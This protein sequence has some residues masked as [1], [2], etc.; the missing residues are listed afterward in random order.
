M[1][2]Q[3]EEVV[4]L[5]KERIA[6]CQDVINS[7]SSDEWDDIFSEVDE[8]CGIESLSAEEQRESEIEVIIHLREEREYYAALLANLSRDEFAPVISALEDERNGIERAYQLANTLSI[9][10][11]SRVRE[12]HFAKVARYN[13][14]I[15]TLREILPIAENG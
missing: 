13:R 15:A 1:N 11:S 7:G 10:I 3:L 2:E 9:S 8:E 12:R 5:L 6:F 14:C 4:E